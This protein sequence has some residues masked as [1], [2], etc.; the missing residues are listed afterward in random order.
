LGTDDKL[1]LIIMRDDSRVRRYRI[2]ISWFR[3][4][5]YAQLVLLLAAGLGA[6]GGVTF[7]FKNLELEQTNSNLQD[8]IY[9]MQIQLERLQ[10]I[11]EILKTNDPEEI[12]ALFSSVSRDKQALPAQKIDLQKVFVA[13]DL[14]MAGVSNLQLREI[15]EKLR[16]SFELNNLTDTTLVGKTSVY[17]ITRDAGV[18][19]A[20]GEENELSFEIQ[21]FRRVNSILHL[22]PNVAKDDIFALRLAIINSEGESIYIQTYPFVNI[23]TSQLYATS[24]TF[25]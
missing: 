17:F 14:Q 25:A 19:Q 1:N 11:K 2:R 22:P 18:I 13:K 9:E 12:H 4:F 15:D 24:L 3:F 23:L 5:L 8:N 16:L 7:W 6:Y 21:R 10:N 20:E